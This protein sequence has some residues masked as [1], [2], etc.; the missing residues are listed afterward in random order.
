MAVEWWKTTL[1]RLWSAYSGVTVLGED[2]LALRPKESRPWAYGT[3]W[4]GES[5]AFSP[6]GAPI[7]AIFFLHHTH[8][9]A[10]QP[11][12]LERAVEGLLAHSFLPTYVPQAASQELDFC[13]NLLREV[14]AYTF[15]FRPDDSAV[16]FIRERQGRG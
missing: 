2:N 11:L 15:G 16:R 9:N 4:I 7:H 12:P 3:P 14:P 6:T 5:R 1:A 10:L 8:E 13:L